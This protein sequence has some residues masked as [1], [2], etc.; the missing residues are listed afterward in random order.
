M[1]IDLNLLKFSQKK[2][3][4]IGY[5]LILTALLIGFFTRIV[6]CFRY[7]TF[8]IG[9]APD[10][11]RDAFVYMKMWEGNF[12]TLGP[13]SS[14]GGYHLPPLY[15]Y[16]VFPFTIFGPNP[17][18]QVIPNALFSFL[19]VILLIYFLDQLL[20]KIEFSQRLL[21]SSLGGLWYSTFYGE[22]FI[23]TFE[24]NPGPIIFFF[25]FFVLLYKF[26]LNGKKSS[27]K[28][29]S[30]II[31]GVV[32]A[33][34]VSLHSTTMFIMPVLFTVSVIFFLDQRRK[35]KKEWLFPCLSV[36]SVLIALLPYWKGEISRNFDNTIKII[37]LVVNSSES[38]GNILTRLSRALLPYFELGQQSYFLGYSSIN[39]LISLIF[40]TLI[41]YIG[42]SKFRGNVILFRLLM[43][44]WLL[45][46][47]SSSSFQGNFNYHYKLLILILPI[48]FT[49]SSLAYVKF[50]KRTYKYLFNSIVVVAIIYSMWTNIYWDYYYLAS[51]YGEERIMATNDIVISIN[52]V[53][54]G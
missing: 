34:L 41:T 46:I 27:L 48:I 6:S 15:Y 23:N 7:I 25:L 5:C 52:V 30:W 1:K 49:I 38:S 35:D 44:S 2:N 29:I 26:Q 17:A 22:I 43:L 12:P 9:P 18:F 32:L 33:I 4:I 11:V 8:D 24:W 16:L 42:I 39:I 50:S 14:I 28:I 36:V 54:V 40:L 21:L 37:N 20:E 51:K 13:V 19:S 47:Y 3:L 31:Y 10:Q 45:Y 53:T